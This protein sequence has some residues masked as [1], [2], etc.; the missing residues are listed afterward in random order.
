M[1]KMTKV[2]LA[3]MLK[4]AAVKRLGEE[5]GRKLLSDLDET[6]QAI[7]ETR[8]YELALEDEPVFFL[9]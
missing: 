7:I 5:R 3:Q 4:E 1:K 6:A 2:Q 8:D 9:K